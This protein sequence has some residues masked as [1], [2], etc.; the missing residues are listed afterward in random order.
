M[1]SLLSS[2]NFQG[3]PAD[4]RPSRYP[5]RRNAFRLANALSVVSLVSRVAGGNR[6]SLSLPPRAIEPAVRM[7]KVRVESADKS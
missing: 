6:E 4:G 2:F 5:P 3:T 7:H 1:P